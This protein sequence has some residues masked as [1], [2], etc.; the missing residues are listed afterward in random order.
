M[1][2]SPRGKYRKQRLILCAILL[3]MPVIYF[4]VLPYYFYA[5]YT[6]VAGDIVF[7]SLNRASDLVRAIEGVSESHYSHCGVVVETND[8]FYVNEA[9]GRVHSTPLLEWIKRGRGYGVDVYRFKPAY[10]PLIPTF[11]KALDPYQNWPYDFQYKLED[12]KMYCS[13]LAFRAYQDATGQN[14]GQL[15]KLGDMNWQPFKA[16]IEKY[17]GGPVPLDR[18][19]IT[20]QALSEAKELEHVL[21]LGW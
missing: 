17:E 16:T 2:I 8:G 5:R 10:T 20:P 6:P 13:E 4:F 12:R 21:S 11:L 3:F 15:I 18:W 19:M 1:K 9:L 7:Q 14:L